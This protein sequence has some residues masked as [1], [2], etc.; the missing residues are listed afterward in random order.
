MSTWLA[1]TT[2]PASCR[3]CLFGWLLFFA[4]FV[5]L[6][7]G[8]YP[9][10]FA[11]RIGIANASH[12]SKS[13]SFGRGSLL[14]ILIVIQFATAMLLI[15]G[16]GML[17]K[18]MDYVRNKDLGHERDYIVQLRFY[19]K[20]RSLL[21]HAEMINAEFK[22]HPNIISLSTSLNNALPSCCCLGLYR[23][24]PINARGL[25]AHHILVGGICLSHRSGHHAFCLKPPGGSNNR[26]GNC[27]C[28]SLACCIY[29]SS[30]S[31]T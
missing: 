30:G 29:K 26:I 17:I 2:W 12:S 22:N 6:T 9:A 24:H 20:D 19:G 5:G 16:S 11:S 14:R 23:F 18:Q 3:T 8:I 31:P 21:E 27:A 28:S 13:P 4:L 15:T 10:L 7:G 25:L 1:N